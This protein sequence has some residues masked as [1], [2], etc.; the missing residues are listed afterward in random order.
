[1]HLYPSLVS[2]LQF[3]ISSTVQ[4]RCTSLSS[5]DSIPDAIITSAAHYPAGA[6]IITGTDPT[7]FTPFQQN[8][9]DMCRVTGI[10]ITSQASSVDFEIWLPD[11]W[12][13]RFLV[14]GNGGLGGCKPSYFSTYLISP[15]TF[16]VTLGVDYANL[17][18][19][20]YMHFATIGTNNGHDGLAD[21]SAFL[22]PAMTETVT[23]FS[24]RA[25]HVAAQ[26]G[27]KV[28][29][30]YYGTDPHHSYYNGCSAGGRQGI[31]VAYRHPED[32][33]GVIAGAPGVDWNGVV[34]APAVWASHVAFKTPSYIPASV[35]NETVSPEILKQCDG[36]D[37]RV[38]EII[39]DPD[40]CH[41][42]PTTLLCTDRDA[43]T[44][45]KCLIQPQVDG[46][47]EF[48]K[49]TLNSDKAVIF[50][51]FDP[52]AEADMFYSFGMNGTL[53]ELTEVRDVIYH[54]SLP[55]SDVPHLRV[56]GIDLVQVRGL[57]QP[58]AT[59]GLGRL[60]R[61]RHHAR[62]CCGP[63]WDFYVEEFPSRTCSVQKQGW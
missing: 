46:L 10:I 24:H 19:G 31:S 61:G 53:P 14:S 4:D 28:T 2:A 40:A 34:G 44:P 41:W 33:D 48:Y 63:G 5:V 52:G 8:S 17:D 20:S 3:P 15:L 29:S 45:S 54:P 49:P 56:D 25:V 36:L 7:C 11:V 27:K 18:Y 23:D 1:M 43:N 55:Q 35:W 51:R 26:V 21:P 60:L 58:R 6:R 57:R 12:Y 30:A 13:G 16:S 22:M 42:D 37:G 62:K 38:D 50:P 39:A 32:F 59:L 9:A 47:K